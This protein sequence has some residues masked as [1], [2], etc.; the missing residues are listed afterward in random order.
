MD[1]SREPVALMPGMLTPEQME[2]LRK[3]K[4]V[5][6]EPLIFDRDDSAPQRR[7][8]NGEGFVDTAGAG[9]MPICSTSRRIGQFAKGEIGIMEGMLETKSLEE[10]R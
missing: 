5:K 10:K 8:D 4:K 7:A 9:R 3:A 2:T 6:F 1:M